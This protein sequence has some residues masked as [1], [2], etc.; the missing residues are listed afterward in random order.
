MKKVFYLIFIILF[1]GPPFFCGQPT[2]QTIN[3]DGDLADWT[4][5]LSNPNNVTIDGASASNCLYSTDRDCPV[6]STG[7]DMVKFAWTY[8]SDNI[9]L[10]VER[11]GSSSN[12]QNFFYI[13]DVNQD[14]VADSNDFVL[15]VSYQG[16]RRLTDITLFK[17][18]PLNPS[19]DSLVDANGFADGYNMP[20]SLISIPSSDPSYFVVNNLTAGNTSGT[21]FESYVPWSKLLVPSGTP[22]FFHVSSGNNASLSQVDDNLGGPGG[23]IGAFAYYWVQIY[24]DN[25]SSIS[26]GQNISFNHTVKNNGSFD[27][28]VDFYSVS[29]SLLAVSI[30]IGPTL[31]AR[32]AQGNGSYEDAEDYLNPSY[33]TNSNNRPDIPLSAW[34]T[35]NITV[36]IETSILPSYSYEVTEIYAVSSGD[37]SFSKAMDQ[38][39]IGDMILYPNNILNGVASEYVYF[40]HTLFNGRADDYIK[41]NVASTLGFDVYL[42]MSTELLGIDYNGNG[43]W[44]YVNTSYDSDADGSPDVYLSN[45]DSISLTLYVPIPSSATVGSSEEITLLASGLT[46]GG[47]TSVTNVLNIKQSLYF[48]PSYSFT[49]GKEMYAASG[50]SIFFSHTIQNNSAFQRKFSFYAPSF[51]P[52]NE[53][54]WQIVIWSDP[55]GD[56]NPSD[57]EVIN[58]T[59]YISPNG[60][61]FNCVVE[62]RIPSSVS[63]PAVSNSS[64]SIV[65]CNDSECTSFDT[66]ITAT[67]EDDLK[68]SYII[69]FSDSNYTINSNNF[70]GC[71]TLYSK[72]FNIAPDQYGRYGIRIVDPNSNTIK[73]EPKNSD[74]SG[75]FTDVYTFTANAITG[76]YRLR[77]IDGG[78]VIDDVPLTIERSG[79]S[80][81]SIDRL[82]KNIEDTLAFSASLLNSNEFVDYSST[83][84]YYIIKDPTET[85]YLTS[86]GSWE[87]LT[88]TSY[89]RLLSPISVLTGENFKSDTNFVSVS[90]PSYGKYSACITWELSCGN[91][92]NLADNISSDCIN[93]Y[94]VNLKS[95]KE[96]ER[97]T[98][99]NNF[100]TSDTIYFKGE[101]YEPLY[102]Y[103]VAIYDSSNNLVG[104]ETQTSESNGN[105]LYTKMGNT[106]SVGSYLFVVYPATITPPSVFSSNFPYTLSTH[107]VTIVEVVLLRFGGVT[108]LNPL[109]PTKPEIFINYPSDPS[110]SLERDAESYG[111]LSGSSFQHEISD[112]STSPPLVF[113]QLYGVIGDTLRVSKDGGKITI[114][115]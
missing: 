55:N 71:L 29:S 31:I 17:Y 50:Q 66:S 107:N 58:N 52:Y 57:G 9:Y 15:H 20:G 38:I 93:F 105:L 69:P 47:S 16:N 12:I 85:L 59:E 60:G 34:A 75:S 73:D 26:P 96:F 101:G 90:F 78:N 49:D 33:D 68:V 46:N 2:L 21:A 80:T 5:V 115:Y 97:T 3:I 89:S 56:G 110:L 35:E 99:Q 74:S 63:P 114:T 32:D 113:Y 36:L 53:N 95:Y 108:S 100:L 103:I 83:K 8:D 94:V 70:T 23:G 104:Y 45:G 37:S 106:L 79:I 61:E 82:G 51:N 19:G 27:D 102:S 77:L 24:P 14:K 18:G 25:L 22:V 62:I 112:L 109:T 67:V 40:D 98:E 84:L 39:Y 4:N 11:I 91:L 44:D 54:G 64:V 41:F 30:Y 7:R 86:S 28:I 48:S 65:K 88:S 72:A 76:T 87:S 1:F 43:S 81:L 10:Y 13:M 92:E 42:Y 111:F 6:Q